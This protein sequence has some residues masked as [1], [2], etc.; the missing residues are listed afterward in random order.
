MAAY[1]FLLGERRPSR[2]ILYPVLITIILYVLFSVFLGI[3]LPR[4]DIPFL[5]NVALALESVFQF[6][7]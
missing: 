2:L 6:L 3:L 5:R 1:G 4:G 7:K